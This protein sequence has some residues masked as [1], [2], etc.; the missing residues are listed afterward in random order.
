MYCI[1][2]WFEENGVEVYDDVGPWD[3]YLAELVLL[4]LNTFPYWH[5]GLTDVTVRR[6]KIVEAA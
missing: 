5:R 6:A 1:R 4:D 2:I 3:H